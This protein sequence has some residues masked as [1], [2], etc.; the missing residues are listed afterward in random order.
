MKE[1]RLYE[2]HPHYDMRGHRPNCGC[3]DFR[4]PN[5]PCFPQFPQMPDC[6][7]W[8]QNNPNNSCPP[9]FPCPPRCDR[10]PSCNNSCNELAIL[11]GGIIIGRILN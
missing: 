10:R 3:G 4:P 8:W 7:N 11:I 9:N 5:K 2:E 6:W 1:Y